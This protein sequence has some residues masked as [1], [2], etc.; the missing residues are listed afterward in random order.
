MGLGSGILDPGS[1]KNL[2]RIPDPGAKKAP[3]SGSATLI[4][5]IIPKKKRIKIFVGRKQDTSKYLNTVHYTV[6]IVILF[7][8]L[9]LLEGWFF[10]LCVFV[11]KGEGIWYVVVPQVNN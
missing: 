5:S 1:G 2:L 11:D 4:K 7:N 6:K 10:Y 8:L 3:D 9:Q